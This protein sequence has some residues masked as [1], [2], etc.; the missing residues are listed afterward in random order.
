[1]NSVNKIKSIFIFFIFLF[2][3]NNLKPNTE[4]YQ[5]AST[6]YDKYKK[7]NKADRFVSPTIAHLGNKYIIEELK[8][9]YYGCWIDFDSYINNIGQKNLVEILT[10]AI[11]QEIKETKNNK[12]HVF[13]H[14][15]NR[16]F[17]PYQDIHTIDIL[18]SC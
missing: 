6:I 2:L 14:A 16:N 10:K 12:K 5:V 11:D 1:M 13:Y 3:N 4:L 8:N 17:L 18:K 9:T 7:Y 15:Q